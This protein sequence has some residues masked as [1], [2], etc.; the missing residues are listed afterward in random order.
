M[1][2]KVITRTTTLKG[3]EFGLTPP[4]SIAHVFCESVVVPLPSIHV[5]SFFSSLR[6]LCFELLKF[7][8]HFLFFR[9]F[10]G[11]IVESVMYSDSFMC[12]SH[13]P[14]LALF[15]APYSLGSPLLHSQND[16]SPTSHTYILPL[17]GRSL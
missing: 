12:A 2:H 15:C 3:G 4:L 16:P 6:L 17:T 8:L 1:I 5:S 9:F 10:S 14:S 11:S 13:F 7:V